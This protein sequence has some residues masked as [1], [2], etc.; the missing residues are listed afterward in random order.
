MKQFNNKNIFKS[1]DG[2][3][4]AGFSHAEILESDKTIVDTKVVGT[5]IRI[6]GF[7]YKIK[8]LSLSSDDSVL[9]AE[10]DPQPRTLNDWTHSVHTNAK[11]KGWWN[12]EP[13]TPLEIHMLCVSELAEATEAV[14]SGDPD[15]HAVER[16]VDSNKIL[17]S[18][19]LE[20]VTQ[21]EISSGLFKPEGEAVEL[22]DCI[23]RI[24][25]YFEYRGWDLEKI[26]L[27]KHAYNKTRAYRHGGKK[28]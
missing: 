13:R 8:S 22:A 11:D 1:D 28:L 2:C 27:A 5:L 15:C 3:L 16:H 4:C 24:M 6:D 9:I 21:E 12:G 10:L 23:I 20:F 18:V 26:M 19:P 14:R 7:V 17:R 25:D